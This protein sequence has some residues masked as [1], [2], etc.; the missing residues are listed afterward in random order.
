MHLALEEL[1]PNDGVDDDH[2]EDQQSNVE[3]RE[4]GL[5]DGVED[6]LKACHRQ[7]GGGKRVTPPQSYALPFINSG[8]PRSEGAKEGLAEEILSP[9]GHP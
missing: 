5:E 9:T 7:Q 1:Q 4:H 2:E 6:Y 8:I 3:Q